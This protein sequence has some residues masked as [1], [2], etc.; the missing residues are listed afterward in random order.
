MTGRQ[1]LCSM[2][3]SGKG[4]HDGSTSSQKKASTETTDGCTKLF[5]LAE[6]NNSFGSLS[7]PDN[8]SNSNNT[9]ANTGPTKAIRVQLGY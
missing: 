5:I 8:N 4:C 9:S 6:V 1:G 2:S 3:C 7:I